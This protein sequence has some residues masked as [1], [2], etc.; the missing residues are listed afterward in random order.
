MHRPV[1]YSGNNKFDINVT[2]VS[3]TR[4]DIG[5][6]VGAFLS[7]VSV[8]G[9]LCGLAV[10]PLMERALALLQAEAVFLLPE[11]LRAPS[12]LRSVL[13]SL[14]RGLFPKEDCFRRLAARL[15]QLKD[16]ALS[17]KLARSLRRV[18]PK[19]RGECEVVASEQGFEQPPSDGAA[20][21]A[22]AAGGRDCFEGG[23]DAR[24]LALPGKV[25]RWLDCGSEAVSVRYA[26]GGHGSGS[27]VCAALLFLAAFLAFLALS[28]V[29]GAQALLA[30]FDRRR[31]DAFSY[32]FAPGELLFAS[33]ENAALQLALLDGNFR[34]LSNVTISKA[35]DQSCLASLSL[36]QAAQATVYAFYYC[37]PTSL[38]L[39]QSNNPS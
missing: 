14:R 28:G 2:K 35:N 12:L 5:Y 10:G 17:L 27:S 3:I 29:F 38:T 33:D 16:V 32:A 25:L 30:S 20:C 24:A 6:I 39:T 21:F 8:L 18:S 4:Y 11:A 36:S 34:T 13:G 7:W 1:V 22:E 9:L 15:E 19:G 26:G 37:L 31:A 23:E